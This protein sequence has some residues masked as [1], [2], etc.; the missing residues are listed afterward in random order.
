M[1]SSNQIIIINKRIPSFFSGWMLFLS[2]NQQCQSTEGKAKQHAD[3]KNM[4]M[5]QICRVCSVYLC[6]CLD[7]RASSN[8]DDMDFEVGEVLM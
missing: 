6:A 7:G 2:P 4:P 5:K 8:L 3:R 1:Q